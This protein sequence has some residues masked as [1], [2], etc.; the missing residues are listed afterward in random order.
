MSQFTREFVGDSPVS[1]PSAVPPDVY[2]NNVIVPFRVLQSWFGGG[3]ASDCLCDMASAN[4]MEFLSF[5]LE[6][7]YVPRFQ[8]LLERHSS[9]AAVRPLQSSESLRHQLH[10]CDVFAVSHIVHLSTIAQW[11]CSRL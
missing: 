1:S 8:V 9:D 10:N 2:S 7:L 3:T 4:Q 6:N 5:D 11:R